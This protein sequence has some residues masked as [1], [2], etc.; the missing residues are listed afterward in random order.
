MRE[1]TIPGND[2]N[3]GQECRSESV[4]RPANCAYKLDGR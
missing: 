4:N 2:D 3:K 1:A